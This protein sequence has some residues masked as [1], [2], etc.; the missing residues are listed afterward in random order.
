VKENNSSLFLLPALKLNIPI[1]KANGLENVYLGD[2]NYEVIYEDSLYLLFSPK[3]FD[4]KFEEFCQGL[5]AVKSFIDEYDVIGNKVMF[6]F[7]FPDK[8]KAT[9]QAFKTGEYSK[10]D[11]DYIKDSFPPINPITKLPSKIHQIL[12]KHPKMKLE[13]MEK[14]NVSE[15]VLI[16]FWEK[17]KPEEEIY[18][19]N[20]EFFKEH[21]W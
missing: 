13:L 2:H 7:K 5:R 1:L 11:K 14:Y 20:E 9:L 4:D 8:L 10:F 3:E 18:N 21:K 17:P 12:I 19:Y 16:E 15:D 6:V